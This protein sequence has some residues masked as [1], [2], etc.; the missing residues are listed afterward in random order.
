MNAIGVNAPYNA[1]PL[2]HHQVNGGIRDTETLVKHAETLRQISITNDNNTQDNKRE[3]G[4]TRGGGVT[5]PQ[6]G[7]IMLRI[8][9]SD[10]LTTYDLDN[11]I[12]DIKARWIFNSDG[13]RRCSIQ[14]H[15]DFLNNEVSLQCIS[16]SKNL[17]FLYGL[18]D[19]VTE[20]L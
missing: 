10:L 6:A 5:L 15:Q 1:L 8:F 16:L 2:H 18:D 7:L 19:F 13:E 4:V 11:L 20:V 3:R 9:L 14:I 17:F 12:A